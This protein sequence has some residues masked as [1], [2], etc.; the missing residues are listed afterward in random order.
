MAY[1][2]KGERAVLYESIAQVSGLCRALFFI[3]MSSKRALPT[4]QIHVFSSPSFTTIL[5]AP[6]YLLYCFYHTLL[7]ALKFIARYASNGCVR[8]DVQAEKEA[9]G[10]DVHDSQVS[11]IFINI[12]PKNM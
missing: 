2:H 6:T 11:Q 12:V 1:K 5:V 3:L 9:T 10:F 4:T 8:V 7:T